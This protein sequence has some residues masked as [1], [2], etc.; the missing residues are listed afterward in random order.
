MN[1]LEDKTLKRFITV[2]KKNISKDR[3]K[4]YRIVLEDIYKISNKTPS[5]I[6]KIAKEEQKPYLEKGTIVFLEI[7]ERYITLLLEQYHGYLENEKKI[8][9]TTIK[10]Y[11]SAFRTFLSSHKIELPEKIDIDIPK[12][13]IK[14]GDI[15]TK[16]EISSSVE[17][18]GSIRDKAIILFLATSGIRSGDLRNF[19]ISDLLE[20]TKDYHDGTIKSLLLLK[21]KNI[22]PTWHFMPSKTSKKGNVCVTFN[23]PES[24]DYLLRYLKTREKLTLNS[25]LFA[26]VHGNKLSPYTL[27]KMFARINDNIFGR[28]ENGKRFF[29]AHALRK[30]FISTCNHNSGDLTKVNLLS[31]HSMQSIV[32][33]SYNEINIE[34]MKRFYMKLIPYLSIRDTKV[35]DIK[36]KDL[37]KIKKLEEEAKAKDIKYMEIEER[38]AIQEEQNKR[39]MELLNNR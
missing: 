2:K 14:E 32:H 38:L 26:T 3:K 6:I 7:E 37:I 30:F 21:D 20:A 31:G 15:P 29:H 28:D 24:F 25:P 12:K 39:I 22:I 17:S 19:T 16:K 1:I 36:H 9:P 4:L 13:L 27:I 10:D 11:T 18:T 5:E 33:D 8:S 34:V 23:T 35:H